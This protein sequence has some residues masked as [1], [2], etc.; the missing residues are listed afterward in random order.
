MVHKQHQTVTDGINPFI[1]RK[2]SSKI[3]TVPEPEMSIRDSARN[4]SIKP[5]INTVVWVWSFLGKGGN[6]CSNELI[7]SLE[8]L[9]RALINGSFELV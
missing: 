1:S 3:S 9:G 5:E 7:S 2:S 8:C 6:K 4:D